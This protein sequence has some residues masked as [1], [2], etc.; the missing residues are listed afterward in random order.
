LAEEITGNRSLELTHGSIH[1]Q[2]FAE[3]ASQLETEYTGQPNKANKN[4]QIEEIKCNKSEKEAIQVTLQTDMP[5]VNLI[6][7]CQIKTSLKIWRCNKMLQTN[8]IKVFK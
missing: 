1:S 8:S 4:L 2:F 7:T 3:V 5:V 6:T